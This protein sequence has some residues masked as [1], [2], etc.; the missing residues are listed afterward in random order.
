MCESRDGAGGTHARLTLR[1]EGRQ[2]N[3]AP[4]GQHARVA[5]RPAGTDTRP[6]LPISPHIS[7]YLPI[8][9]HITTPRGQHARTPHVPWSSR[10]QLSHSVACG[11]GQL[12]VALRSRSPSLQPGAR[13][14]EERDRH[15]ARICKQA[16]VWDDGTA[17]E[18][19]EEMAPR[20]R[21][22]RSVVVRD[23][24]SS[25]QTL[26]VCRG[27]AASSLTRSR[28]RRRRRRCSLFAVSL[29]L[30]ATG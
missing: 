21:V 6:D 9:P 18:A 1:G 26:A 30:L 25:H 7:P 20:R 3:S 24:A 14:P 5:S 8:S 11:L 22:C 10:R 23:G 2:H 17:A 16:R 19:E 4:R 12:K 13:R 29:G 15:P 27:C 28:R